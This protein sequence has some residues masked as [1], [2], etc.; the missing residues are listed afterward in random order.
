MTRKNDFPVCRNPDLFVKLEHAL[1]VSRRKS[2][3]NNLTV[4]LADST[5][6][7]KILADTGIDPMKRAENLSVTEL[8]SLSDITDDAIISRKA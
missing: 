6:A 1:F 4:F 5:A 2:V 8:L 3:K 7:S